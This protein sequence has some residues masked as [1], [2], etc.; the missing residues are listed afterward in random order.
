MQRWIAQGQRTTGVCRPRFLLWRTSDGVLM[1]NAEPA[2][3]TPT[4]TAYAVSCPRS[5]SDRNPNSVTLLPWAKPQ[6]SD[7]RASRS[8]SGLRPRQTTLS[9]HH[10]GSRAPF[11]PY[12]HASCHSG[13]GSGTTRCVT[14]LP[15]RSQRMEWHEGL[16]HEAYGPRERP[17]EIAIGSAS[18][19]P[20]TF[21]HDLDS[22]AVPG[23]R[24]RGPVRIHGS[25]STR[26]DSAL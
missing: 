20:R 7:P 25:I 14:P 2:P 6:G 4:H 18:G 17:P 26:L 12:R 22:P 16:G 9:E 11:R 1:R 3:G 13:S 5:R 23:R 8:P 19:P 24:V 21:P 15:G 10:E